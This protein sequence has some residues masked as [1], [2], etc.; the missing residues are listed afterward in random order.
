VSAKTAKIKM[1]FSMIIA[2]SIIRFLL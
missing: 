2:L 1:P